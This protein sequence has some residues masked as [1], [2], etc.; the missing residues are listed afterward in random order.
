MRLTATTALLTFLFTFI[1]SGSWWQ[2]QTGEKRSQGINALEDLASALTRSAEVAGSSVNAVAVITLLVVV[3]LIGLVAVV[4]LIAIA[5]ELV[6]RARGRTSATGIDL[7]HV[8]SWART[9]GSMSQ[10]LLS[11]YV[12][13]LV[14]TALVAHKAGLPIAVLTSTSASDVIPAAIVLLATSFPVQVASRFVK[15][16]GPLFRKFDDQFDAMSLRRNVLRSGTK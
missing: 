9:V 13:V 14:S 2:T 12:A 5:S 15:V 10:R 4:A 16:F 6:S 11:L 3:S 8:I 1:L 7:E